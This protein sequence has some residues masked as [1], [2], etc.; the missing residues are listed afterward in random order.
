MEDK[1]LKLTNLFVTAYLDKDDLVKKL[2]EE[3]Q[4]LKE[5]NEELLEY[6]KAFEASRSAGVAMPFI[7]GDD[8]QD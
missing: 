5:E 2:M 6:K 1:E 4:K 7:R 8:N 3:N